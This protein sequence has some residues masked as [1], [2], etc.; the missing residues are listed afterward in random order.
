MRQIYPAVLDKVVFYILLY[1]KAADLHRN[2]FDCNY[3][4]VCVCNI[5][6]NNRA[7]LLFHSLQRIIKLKLEVAAQMVEPLDAILV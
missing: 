6:T 3:R 4:K 2:R 1:C 7:I 5:G